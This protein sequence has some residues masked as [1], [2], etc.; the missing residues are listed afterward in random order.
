MTY[1]TLETHALVH[2]AQID[3]QIGATDAAIGHVNL[4]FTRSWGNSF[5]GL[6]AKGLVAT[7]HGAFADHFVFSLFQNVC[8][9]KFGPIKTHPDAWRIGR[10][11]QMIFHHQRP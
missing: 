10:D 8:C 3:M 1:G 4:H 7:I 5:R 6:D 9:G 11:G 2:M